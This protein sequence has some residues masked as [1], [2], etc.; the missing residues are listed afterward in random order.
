MINWDDLRFCLALH[1]HGSMVK[2]AKSLR[3]NVATVS[4][5]IDHITT[6][7]GETIFIRSGHEWKTTGIGVELVK[8]ASEIEARLYE[9][10]LARTE[11][12]SNESTVRMS[13]SLTILKTFMKNF[14][15]YTL[16]NGQVFN[17][18]LT[19]Y[20]RSV[21][22]SE[23]DVAV[24][25]TRPDHGNY[26]C[27]KV[28]EVQI[29]PYVSSTAEC[30]PKDWLEVEYDDLKLHPRDFGFDLPDIPKLR[31]V[32]L[33]LGAQSVIQGNMLGF[34]PTEFADQIPNLRRAE[35]SVK[36][37]KLEIW[38]VY[39]KTRKLDPIVRAAV[40]LITGSFQS[41]LHPALRA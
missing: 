3:A 22:Y 27:A 32:G 13:V 34:F 28:A 30:V 1:R 41:N 9:M 33:N 24:R 19:I 18:D 8:L 14:T 23:I 35:T 31:I 17:V 39:H 29:A 11:P 7:V 36:P 10:E 5:R 20:D 25:Y 21:A 38:M 15:S 4:R 16:N 2:A 37:Q 40:E 6:D 12:L 26:I